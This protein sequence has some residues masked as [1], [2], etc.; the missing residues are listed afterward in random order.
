[1]RTLENLSKG[2]L[3]FSGCSNIPTQLNLKKHLKGNNNY[4]QFFFFLE[5]VVFIWCSSLLRRTFSKFQKLKQMD[6]M[7]YFDFFISIVSLVISERLFSNYSE[8]SNSV[9]KMISSIEMSN[10]RIC[11]L[12]MKEISNFV[13]LALQGY[14][15]SIPIIFK[16]LI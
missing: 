14:S 15:K 5:R 1:M 7:Y 3:K 4:P 2:K 9:I 8:Q 13:I 6:W 16:S 11:L 12:H 10:Q